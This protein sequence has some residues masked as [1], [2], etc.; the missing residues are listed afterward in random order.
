MNVPQGFVPTALNIEWQLL[1]DQLT[2][3]DNAISVRT[4]PAVIG[5][6]AQIVLTVEG[7]LSEDKV[8]L[9][10]L[11]VEN[12]NPDLY[13]SIYFLST[14]KQYYSVD[15]CLNNNACCSFLR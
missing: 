10:V 15:L 12:F 1:L 2:Q 11:Y 3:L 9:A 4:I 7:M 13:P 8:S 14:T 6:L 5:A